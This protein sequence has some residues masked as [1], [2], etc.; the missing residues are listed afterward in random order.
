MYLDAKSDMLIEYSEGA[1]DELIYLYFMSL[2]VALEVLHEL[3]SVSPL[4]CTPRSY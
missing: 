2:S 3:Y 1:Y 4:S